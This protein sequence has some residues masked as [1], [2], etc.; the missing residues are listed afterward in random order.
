MCTPSFRVRLAIGFL[1]RR[2]CMGRY[3]LQKVVTLAFVGFSLVSIYVP[4]A[5]GQTPPSIVVDTTNQYPCIGGNATFYVAATGS[6]PMEVWWYR[7]NVMY[8]HDQIQTNSTLTISNVQLFNSGETFFALVYN[9]WGSTQSFHATLFVY[10]PQICQQ[11]NNI[12]AAV[13]SSTNFNV[14]AS[15]TLPLYYQWYFQGSP[16]TNGPNVSGVNSPTLFINNAQTNNSGSYAVV[17]TNSFGAVTSRVAQCSIGLPPTAGDLLSRIVRIG[18]ST[19]FTNSYGGSPT[20]FYQWFRNDVLLPGATASFFTVP[21]VQRP[22]IGL[23]HVKVTNLFGV[24][25]S[26]KA[27]LQA[28]LTLEGTS[29]IFREEAT[30]EIDS[31]TNAVPAFV[32]PPTAIYHGVPLLFSTYGATAK[33]WEAN[34]CNPAPSHTMWVRYQSPRSETNK[35]STEGSGFDT[36]V[37]VYQWDN[38]PNHNPDFIDCDDDSG[39]DGQTSLLYFSTV[40]GTTYYIAVDGVAGATGTVRLQVG[41]NIRKVA[42]NPANGQFRFEVAGTLWKTNRLRTTTNFMPPIFW[43]NLL[44]VPV[45]NNDWVIGYTNASVYSNSGRF[46]NLQLLP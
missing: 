41:E 25:V 28:R 31:L 29:P 32:P 44:T 1:N 35:I 17:V 43:Q 36:V 3:C 14:N 10:D 30:D 19:T 18:T 34:I 5:I 39:F 8:F 7:N 13:G 37:S 46:Y 26:S 9:Q 12:S 24:T 27:H 45:T 23:Y 38:N 15:G 33:S 11:P 6:Q 20:L 42:F 16:M 4:K 40:A 21:N 2:L 22:Q